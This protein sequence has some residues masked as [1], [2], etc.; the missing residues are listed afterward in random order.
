MKE[1]QE[2]AAHF[3]L[4]AAKLMKQS[5]HAADAGQHDLAL[6][7][8]AKASA[9]NNAAGAARYWPELYTEEQPKIATN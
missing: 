4:W 3:E 5:V 2:L 8:L 7:L 6:R 9:M 1:M